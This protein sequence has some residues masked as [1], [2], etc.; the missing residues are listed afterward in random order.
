[1]RFFNAIHTK[2][3]FCR[4]KVFKWSFFPKLRGFWY[5]R[6]QKITLLH[7]CSSL[8]ASVTFTF[9]I[10]DA[11]DA[12]STL[13]VISGCIRNSSGIMKMLFLCPSLRL[14]TSREYVLVIQGVP[15]TTVY[16]QR[17]TAPTKNIR[18]QKFL[19]WHFG[20]ELIYMGIICGNI[21]WFT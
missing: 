11:E 5:L 10:F 14:A 20:N 1:M 8:L 17:N 2:F 7:S 3:Y 15:F 18:F 21:T 19:H 6:K 9:S 16:F 4:C 13:K 12:L